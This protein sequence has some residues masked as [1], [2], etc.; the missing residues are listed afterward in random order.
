MALF[1]SSPE[2]VAERWK[3]VPEALKNTVAIA[4]ACNV[5]LQLDQILI[6]TFPTPNNETEHDYLQKLC[7]Q[8]A[9]WRYGDIAHEDMHLQT[10]EKAR[11]VLA[12]EII[13]RLDYELGIISKMGYEGY[14]LI[15][16]DFINWGKNQGIIFGPG[17]GS[18][19]G[20]IVAF[21]MNITD[22]NPLEYDLLFE[23]FLNP[24]RI[25]MPDIDIDIQDTRRG[26][27]IDYV[28]EKY[29]Q[30]RVAQIITF[31][32]MAARNAVRD[33]GRALGMSYAEVDAIAKKIPAPVQGRHIPL[34]TS[35]K[36]DPELR[37]EYDSNPR[38]KNLIDLAMKLEGTIRSNG[39]H[40][41]GVVIAADDIVK[42]TP[43][44]RAQKGG[45]CTQ[46]SMGPIEQL[47]LLKMDFLGLSNLTIIKNTLRIVKKVYSK[48]IDIAEIPLDDKKTYELFS[49]GDTTGL[50]QFES[51]GMKRYLR[52]LKP[53]RFDDLIAMN[54]LYRPGPMQWI[55]DFIDRK[56]GRKKVEYLHPTMQA[57]LEPTHGIIVYQEQVMQISKEMCGFTGGQADSLRKA[58]AKKQPVEM[59]KMKKAFIEGAMK[60][61]GADKTL[62]E[63]FWSQLEAFA[64][65]AFPK[66]HSACYAL[67]AVQTAYLKAN[68][69]S[70]FMAALMTSN[71]DNIDKIS[72]EISEC[73]RMGINVLSPDIN[74]SFLEFGIV[75]DSNDIRFG[76]AAIKNV[77]TGAINTIL[78]A[79]EAGGPFKS[80]E[81]FAKRVSA[82]ECNRKVWE[83]LIKSG[84]MDGFGERSQLL[85]NLDS[86]T[87]YAS[88]AQ[89]NALS[90]QI[91][92]FG[93]LGEDSMPGLR[94]ELP[95]RV[96]PA[97]EQLGWERE[98][99]GLFLS[100]HPLDDY[101]GYLA[102]HT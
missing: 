101:E 41:A 50:F 5:E 75:P 65:Y 32:T 95:E 44:L 62:M 97:R 12:P 31:G 9:M 11:K 81:D 70:A 43:L 91:D 96:I 102:D 63:D 40:A 48:D 15:V 73:R 68:Y 74:E 54:A 39:V 51:A 56:H 89:K 4:D 6:P 10:E 57:A 99:L 18:A 24:D 53:T 36:Q 86:I 55:E 8:G 28:T 46:Y 47:G 37:G 1:I 49:R 19:A 7:W 72:M 92:I 87:S 64:A 79:R 33:T 94:L 71:Y 52:S 82:S 20:S 80:V 66:S 25:S 35:I 27:V 30:D 45:I 90:G 42:F 34:A 100:Q 58:V 59:A 2:E 16:A 21:S 83:A 3:H 67:I 26:E 85:H 60:T 69:P 22:L 88:K 29:G 23:R 38:A 98:L 13:E 77:G 61:S 93:S 17:R 84:A 14:F 76:M 78:Q